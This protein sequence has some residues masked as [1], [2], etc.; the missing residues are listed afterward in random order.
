MPRLPIS[1]IIPYDIGI[2]LPLVMFLF[3]MTKQ[4]QSMNILKLYS[5]W[6]S[7]V[8]YSRHQKDQIFLKL[9]WLLCLFFHWRRAFV[10]LYLKLG[11]FR[12]MH[13]TKLRVWSMQMVLDYPEM[14]RNVKLTQIYRDTKSDTKK[15]KQC[16]LD[17]VLSFSRRVQKKDTLAHQLCCIN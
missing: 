14:K 6:L 5:L 1:L 12:F 8:T 2:L 11:Q 17:I 15:I 16:S 3:I 7:G 4:N 9:Q 10:K 13:R